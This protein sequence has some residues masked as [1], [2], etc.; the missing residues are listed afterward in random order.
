VKVPHGLYVI[1]DN[2]L[3]DLLLA[4]VEAA[5]EGGAVIVQYRNK[6]G[7]HDRR[8]SEAHSLLALCRR[9]HRPLLIND[10]VDLALAVGADGVHLGRTDG[11]LAAARERLGPNAIIG[12][13]CHDSLGCAAEA[14]QG[15]ADYLAFGAMY[16]SAT[17]PGAR[18]ADPAL[19]GLAKVRFGLPVVAIGGINTDNA[20]ELLAAGADCLAVIHDIFGRPLDE[21]RHRA[22]VYQGLFACP[23]L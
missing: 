13:T 21:I 22:A 12:A 23:A 16:P 11:S 9:H 1:T 18:R 15:G 7:D 20:P 2:S 17:K 8:L 6:S 19:L 14:V 10:D 4:A 5:L 3:G